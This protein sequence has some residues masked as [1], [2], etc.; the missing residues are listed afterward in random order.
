MRRNIFIKSMMRQP[1]R[2]TILV[3]IVAAAAF[4]FVMRAAEY[5]VVTDQIEGI[6]KY[7]RSI[8]YLQN[9]GGRSVYND[10]SPGAGIVSKSKYVDFED[11][12]RAAMGILQD[13]ANSHLYGGSPEYNFRTRH[14]TDSYFYGELIDKGRLEPSYVT[15][16]TFVWFRFL[17]DNVLESC[18]GSISTGQEILVRY[19]LTDAEMAA[20]WEARGQYFLFGE[21][22]PKIAEVE[23]MTIGGRYF[24]RCSSG[25]GSS[26][27]ALNAD[28][29]P[30]STDTYERNVIQLP[31][32]PIWYMP[33]DAGETIS[34]YAPGFEWLSRELALMRQSQRTVQLLTT[35]D[36][37]AMPL[38]QPQNRIMHLV[39][40]RWLDRSDEQSAKPVAVVNEFFAS[41]NNLSVGDIL[42]IDI[43]RNQQ[44]VDVFTISSSGR[45]FS[46][47]LMDSPPTEQ[48]DLDL[49]LEIVGVFGFRIIQSYQSAPTTFASTYI[50]IPDSCL[51]PGIE[52]ISAN[53]GFE[54]FGWH[55]GQLYLP[56]FRYSFVLSDSR[57]ENAF[58]A[59]SALELEALGYDLMFIDSGAANFW[60]SADPIIQAVTLN[61]VVFSALSA[62]VAIIT[63]FLYLK[64]RKKDFAIMRALGSPASKV[65]MNLM[66]SILV[67][68]LPAVMAGGAAGWYFASGRIASTLNPFGDLATTFNFS[69]EMSAP[70]L[71]LPF[72][73]AAVFAL[74]MITAA[75]GAR[76]L[77]RRPVL[78]LL[79]GGEAQPRV[80]NAERGEF[81]IRNAERGEFGIRN[82]EC[83]EF[84][85][86]NSECGIE[87]ARSS[88]LE[89]A[90]ARSSE[91]EIEQARSSEREIEQARSSDLEIA[92]ARSSELEIAQARSSELEIAQARSSE[93]EIAHAR[94]SESEIGLPPA[95]SHVKAIASDVSAMNTGKEKKTE[96]KTVDDLRRIFNPEFRNS[97][98]RYSEFRIPNSE[99]SSFRI[100]NSEFSRLRLDFIL[101]FISRHIV[102]SVAKSILTAAVALF[103]IIALGWMQGAID[104]AE[105]EINRLYD[106]TIVTADLRPTNQ[107]SPSPL[108][109]I[110]DLIRPRVV[111]DVISIGYATDIYYE[112]GHSWGMLL[113]PAP[114]GSFP[115]DWDKT[116]GYNHMLSIAYNMQCLDVLIG[117]NDLSMLIGENTGL[118]MYT[119]NDPL[120]D[121]QIEYAEGFSA[122]SFVFTDNRP[123]P[124]II[125][126]STAEKT[127]LA[128]GGIA[129]IHYNK[130]TLGMS[131]A[132]TGA[133]DT[134]PVVVIGVHNGCIR[135]SQLRSSVIMPA[136]ALEQMVG[137]DIGYITIRFSIDPLQNRDLNSIREEMRTITADPTYVPG[138]GVMLDLQINDEELRAVVGSMEQNLSLLLLLYPIAI[139][140][141]V[142]MG[143]GLSM[144]LMLQNSKCAAIMR[145]LGTSK[146][147]SGSKLCAEQLVVCASGLII[148]ICALAV[149]GWTDSLRDS[150]L[151]AGLYLAGVLAGSISGAALITNRPPLE[152]LQVKE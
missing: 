61:I 129:Y 37:T 75:I 136:A 146:R 100:P 81:R 88:E 48:A 119:E 5:F 128:P 62:M 139:A 126:E 33:V 24:I 50:F 39:A 121:M 113:A 144:L 68:A 69:L 26:M 111:Q 99:F 125:P 30:A 43:P 57:Q 141:S 143:L 54:Q 114:D 142:A 148:S 73:I 35:A 110:G 120:G 135:Q 13:M 34:S 93:L 15:A 3:L 55:E 1:V 107:G 112:A 46:E 147:L 14:H 152:L 40:G 133:W 95:P 78:D 76:S 60:A 28:T 58:Q 6:G 63:V 51:P 52:A 145:V 71:W 42:K 104:R 80:N 72:L 25:T 9:S 27:M 70:A 10:V 102:R 127:G 150:I 7:Y 32:Q 116:T 49:E 138:W 105:K 87:Q 38:T 22:I 90:Q 124:V 101:R 2:T 12:R 91:R 79:Q 134:V 151:P 11:K 92:Q 118:L 74:F 109:N 23:S 77:S 65:I 83:G 131:G 132:A 44:A 31:A 108:H 115:E 29:S 8:G 17:V 140:L 94:S 20:D 56:Q 96:Y 89:I 123:I 16:N 98:S 19:Y 64:Q 21:E 41:A 59:S 106:T 67:F 18:Y 82:S 137:G 86:R 85:I 122:S 53:T 84:G 97:N 45:M 130:P 103:F 117:V 47:Y 4:A 36:M 149:L 66:A